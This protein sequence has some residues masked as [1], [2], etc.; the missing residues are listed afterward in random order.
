[1]KK[2]F[3]IRFCQFVFTLTLLIIINNC[4]KE[5]DNPSVNNIVFNPNLTFGSVSDVDGNTYKTI[6]IGTQTWMAENLRT[7][8]YR[9]GELIGTTTPATLDISHESEPKYQWAYGGNES[10]VSV[11]GRLYTRYAVNDSR[12]ICPAGWHIPTEEELSILV[13]YLGGED[14]AGGKLKEVGTSHWNSPNTGATNE[15][16][17]TGLPSGNRFDTGNSPFTDIGECCIFWVSNSSPCLILC[18]LEI[19]KDFNDYNNASGLAVRC[20]KD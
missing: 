3:I 10:N 5:N 19:V 13:T 1:M 6:V 4:K 12:N 18:S 16:G 17:F 20:I 11:Y 8:K 15:S 2:K 9:N 7:T 14:V